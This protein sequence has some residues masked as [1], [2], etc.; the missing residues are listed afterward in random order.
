MS[1]DP[2]APAP[3]GLSVII[4]HRATETVD[5]TVKAVREACG[6]LGIRHEIFCVSGNN[7]TE[8][9]NRCIAMAVEPWIYF[10]DNDS[11]TGAGTF[12]ALRKV[13]EA[14]PDAAVVGGPALLL[15]T[16]E[17]VQQAADAV[18]SSSMAVGKIASRYSARG[19]M[20]LTSDN[21]LILCNLFVRRDVFDCVGLLDSRL[22]P[23][24][25]N[26][27]LDRVRKA[28]LQIVYD[29]GVVIRREQRR[30]I[31]AFARQ[32]FTYG[33]GRGEQT[34]LSPASFRLSLAIPIG[35]TLYL[36][37]L[38]PVA[39][40][41]ALAGAPGVLL[42]AV[43]A[44]LG[45]YVLILMAFMAECAVRLKRLHPLMPLFFL[46]NHTVYG[47]GFA[48]GFTARRFAAQNREFA[49]EV[50]KVV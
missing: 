32:V 18:F 20:R 49:C 39:A 6:T 48:R 25:E 31:G 22:Y 13:L 45:L 2:K 7:P 4:P 10:L 15:P 42:G 23:N 11:V 5:R 9:R 44:P 34:R 16:A 43:A 1:P 17:P 27:F 8:Q 38:L 3:F 21:E 26:E 46:L 24:E 35:F 40:A 50:R 28:G 12:C 19:G 41:L 33:R 37:A 47:L 29:P 30:T 14:Y 36:L